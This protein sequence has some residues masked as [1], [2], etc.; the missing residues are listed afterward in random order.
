VIVGDG[1]ALHEPRVVCDGWDYK[2]FST[3][4]LRSNVYDVVQ[5]KPDDSLTERKL[6][7][8]PKIEFDKFLPEYDLSIYFDSRFTPVDDLDGF[9]TQYHRTPITVMKHNRR[10][11]VYKEAFFLGLENTEQ[12]ERYRRE[13]MSEGFG[14]FA[15][16]ITIRDNIP[17]V[18]DF[19]KVWADQ[20]S[21]YSERDQLSLAYTVWKTGKENIG[22]MPFKKLY[23]EWMGR[24]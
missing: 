17:F 3:I 10:D 15:P 19:C 6:S 1:Y 7:R 9:V 8:G 14:L 11:C 18:R 12:I 5:L 21:R 2:V 16:G 23:S 20:Y 22:I 13:G 24:A 4:Q